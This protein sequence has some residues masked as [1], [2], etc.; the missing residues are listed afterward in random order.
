MK[1][2][3]RM[4]S[5]ISNPYVQNLLCKKR[6][7]YFNEF[8]YPIISTNNILSQNNFKKE[9]KSFSQFENKN[10]IFNCKD[11]CNISFKS[12]QKKIAHHNRL[13]NDCNKEKV[14]LYIL[15]NEFQNCINELNQ[16]FKFGNCNE[17]KEM[18]KQFKKSKNL[19]FDKNLWNNFLN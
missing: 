4:F 19:V 7:R 2:K 18:E 14:N 16:N 13:D 6:E 8:P 9:I 5:Y 17:F 15:L 12:L 3:K 1:I 11:G 10:T